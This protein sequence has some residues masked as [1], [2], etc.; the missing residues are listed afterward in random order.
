MRK[1]YIISK[2][3]SEILYKNDSFSKSRV[4]LKKAGYMWLERAVERTRSWKVQNEIGKLEPKLESSWRSWKIRVSSARTF[5]LQRNFPTSKE[6][7][8]LR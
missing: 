2:I 3:I 1:T 8:Q 6:T 5:Q 7:F 4:F